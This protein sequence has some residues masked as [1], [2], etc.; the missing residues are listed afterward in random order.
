MYYVV[1]YVCHVY[2]VMKLLFPL[3]HVRG[4]SE[5]QAMSDARNTQWGTCGFYAEIARF[6]LSVKLDIVYCQS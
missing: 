1:L 3:C 2:C 4:I 6:D 5:W